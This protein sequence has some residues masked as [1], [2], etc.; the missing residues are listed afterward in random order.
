MYAT[1]AAL[2]DQAVPADEDVAED[3]F[4]VLPAFVGESSQEPI[5]S[6]IVLHSPNGNFAIRQ[7][8]WKYIEGKPSPT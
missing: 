7:G 4:N 3:S 2:L 6:S 5:R 8:P 1:I